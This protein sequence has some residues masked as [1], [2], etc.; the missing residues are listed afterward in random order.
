V[1][2]LSP[3][4]GSVGS[5]A[6]PVPASAELATEAVLPLLMAFP[7]SRALK[8]TRPVLSCVQGCP[9]LGITLANACS[10]MLPPKATQWQPPV[11]CP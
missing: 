6:I 9:G 7:V 1:P 11:S 2:K 4:L 3:P 8:A 10:W 5:G